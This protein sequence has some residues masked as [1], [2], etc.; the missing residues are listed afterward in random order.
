[1]VYVH[2]RGDLGQQFDYA[3]S[4]H[5][6]AELLRRQQSAGEPF[7]IG[8]DGLDISSYEGRQSH[9]VL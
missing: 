7:P 9:A 8:R 3:V 2:I 5:L 1:L 4:E 6:G